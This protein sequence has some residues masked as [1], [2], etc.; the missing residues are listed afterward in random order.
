MIPLLLNTLVLC[1]ALDEPC[2]VDW[3]GTP[4]REALGQLSARIETPYV[5]DADA[6]PD[7]LAAPVRFAARYLTGRQVVRWLA[8]YARLDAAIIEGAILIA[9]P[10]RIPAVL[11]AQYNA[12]RPLPPRPDRRLDIHWEETT[13]SRIAAEV[14]EAF[15]I[16]MLFDPKVL[17]EAPLVTA[18]QPAADLEATCRLVTEQ[19]HAGAAWIDGAIY[20]APAG[21]PMTRPAEPA[22]AATKEPEGALPAPV[23]ASALPLRKVVSV[24]VS[25]KNWE[26]LRARFAA[27]AG[28]PCRL[29][30]N[31]SA[32]FPQM[33]AQGPMLD[34]LES[35]RLAGVLS[36]RLAAAAG[37]TAPE[38]QITL[39]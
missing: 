17:E 30:G 19:L 27:A 35:L 22:P 23:P 13:L 12:A 3:R 14:A 38:L 20:V 36:W 7:R 31:Q 1:A 6:P 4:L 5:V 18:S 8:R 26:E 11:R 33:A 10:D 29:G 21:S 28:L 32:P 2:P 16:D 24:D 25:V 37:G 15:E 39:R 9:G 34:I